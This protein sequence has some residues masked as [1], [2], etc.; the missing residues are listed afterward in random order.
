MKYGKQNMFSSP[1]Y[2]PGRR[3][4]NFEFLGASEFCISTR[5]PPNKRPPRQQPV[6]FLSLPWLPLS[7]PTLMLVCIPACKTGFHPHPSRADSPPSAIPRVQRCICQ[8]CGLSRRRSSWEEGCN[9]WKPAQ[10]H[11]GGGFRRPGIRSMVYYT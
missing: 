7:G 1:A 10:G 6:L 11:S 2:Q 9:S 3:G 8:W 4:L 5:W